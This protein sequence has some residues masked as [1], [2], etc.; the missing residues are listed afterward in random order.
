MDTAHCVDAAA[1]RFD[2]LIGHQI[3]TRHTTSSHYSVGMFR[4]SLYIER[5]MAT[6]QRDFYLTRY[7]TVTANRD[8]RQSLT[9]AQDCGIRK[10]GV[11][12]PALHMEFSFCSGG[13]LE[14]FGEDSES[15]GIR[16]RDVRKTSGRSSEVSGIA[17]LA[18]CC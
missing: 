10:G 7:R 14:R 13:I 17:G 5:D 8:D 12:G 3:F 4:D 15:F 11:C 2:I 18:A 1:D 6:T 9:I 16:F